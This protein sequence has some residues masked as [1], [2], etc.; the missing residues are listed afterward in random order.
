[1]TWEVVSNEPPQ[2]FPAYS[3]G[4]RLQGRETSVTSL[5][6][7]LLKI[8]EVKEEGDRGHGERESIFVPSSKIAFFLSG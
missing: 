7:F 6:I 1:M 5:T 2:S 4:Y 8:A 3:G